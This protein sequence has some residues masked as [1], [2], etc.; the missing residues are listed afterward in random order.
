MGRPGPFVAPYRFSYLMGLFNAGW[1]WE[2][3]YLAGRRS[4]VPVVKIYA[5][6]HVCLLGCGLPMRSDSR[7]HLL[8][9]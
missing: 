7:A 1:P 6:D 8:S 3:E 9:G 4:S 5:C 2:Q